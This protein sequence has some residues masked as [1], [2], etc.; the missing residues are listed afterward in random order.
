MNSPQRLE[1]PYHPDS[2]PLFA[3]LRSGEWS[4]WLD[5][6]PRPAAGP[7]DQARYDI[8]VARPYETLLFEPADG[9]PFAAL[10]RRLGPVR[11]RAF[12]DLPFCGGAVGYFG[13]DLAREIDA[14]ES[15]AEDD[16]KLPPLAFGLYDWAVVVDHQREQSWLVSQGERTTVQE[17]QALHQRLLAA[18]ELMPSKGL[19]CL[20]ELESDLERV[21]YGEAFRRVQHYLR[22]GD[23][24]QVNLARRFSADVAGDPWAFY[25]Q[26]RARSPAPFGAWMELPGLR[27]LSISPERFLSVR[28]GAVETRP[29]KGT[30]ARMAD[31][32]ADAEAREALHGSAKDRAENLMI[33]D[34]LRNDLGRSCRTGSV[35]VPEL[36]AVE[37]YATVHHLVSTVHGQLEQGVDALELL[38]R[39]FPGGS[40]TGAPK[41]RAMQVIEELEPHRRGIYCGAIGYI[42]VDGD[43][44]TNIAIRTAVHRGKAETG[45][46]H[47]WAGGGLVVDSQ[48]ELEYRETEAKARAFIELLACA[49]KEESR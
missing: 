40:I 12:D 37:S 11:A 20:T 32:H 24:Y 26:L 4:I 23:C 43:M 8:M 25:Q 16:L 15:R 35:E 38:R 27:V 28:D 7:A 13:Y 21:D 29:I 2:T 41:L 1:L 17:L 10:R 39:A 34:L 33:V 31:P 22:E 18:S 36:F 49:K 19:S 44:D 6:G 45:E 46:L 30:V 5:S 9:D 42:G 47:F 3:A 48:E 14:L